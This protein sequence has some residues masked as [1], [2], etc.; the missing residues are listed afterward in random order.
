MHWCPAPVTN[1]S[2]SLPRE[3]KKLVKSFVLQTMCDESNIVLSEELRIY[4]NSVASKFME[5]FGAEFLEDLNLHK[6]DVPDDF[7]DTFVSESVAHYK[8]RVKKIFAATIEKNNDPTFRLWRPYSERGIARIPEVICN[9]ILDLLSDYKTKVGSAAMGPTQE[10]LKEPFDMVR[11]E[12]GNEC[13]QAHHPNQLARN[14]QKRWTIIPFEINQNEINLQVHTHNTRRRSGKSVGLKLTEETFPD[15]IAGS[16]CQVVSVT[17][18]EDGNNAG[19]ENK[20]IV[21]DWLARWDEQEQTCELIEWEAYL[22]IIL[23]PPMKLH[24]LRK[25]LVGSLERVGPNTPS[26]PSPGPNESG[27]RT[28]PRLSRKVARFTP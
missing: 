16:H 4:C 28:S 11:K 12:K 22:K 8:A 3:F 24:F 6:S 2:T 23:L 27:R 14:F 26:T 5:D 25:K 13:K 10:E 1:D 7:Y 15:S 21:G 18:P 20:P 9:Q 19:A 17:M